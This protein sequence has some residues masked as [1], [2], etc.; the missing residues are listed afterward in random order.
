MN[1]QSKI[2]LNLGCTTLIY[3]QHA[4]LLTDFTIYFALT[5]SNMLS[6]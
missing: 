4:E 2:R 3:Q 5:A 1:S 6:A